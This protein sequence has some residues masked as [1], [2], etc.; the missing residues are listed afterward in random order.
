MFQ[1][2]VTKSDIIVSKGQEQLVS[3]A[4][5]IYDGFFTFDSEWDG[6]SKV[7]V[8]SNDKD[9]C[10]PI[11]L[12]ES[13]S[14]TIP[15]EVL[16]NAGDKVKVGV[17]GTNGDSENT[18]VLPSVWLPLGTLVQGTVLCEINPEPGPET[19]SL[20]QQLLN[21]ATEAVQTADSVVKRA[22]AGEFNGS[23][24]VIVQSDSQYPLTSQ[25]Y[26]AVKNGQPMTIQVE[27]VQDFLPQD[28][29]IVPIVIKDITRTESQESNA[30]LFFGV[31]KNI[32]DN[33][34]TFEYR[35]EILGG[36]KGEQGPQG[37]Q[38]DP[39]PRGEKGPEGPIGPEGPEGPQGLR[40]PEGPQGPKG[41]QGSKGDQGERGPQGLQGPK[42]DTGAPFQIVKVYNSVAAMESDFN[43]DD[44]LLGQFVTIDTGNVND[45]DNAKLFVKSESGWL[46]LTDLSGAQG[47]QGPIGPEGPQGVQGLRGL[48]GEQGPKGDP[49]KSAYEQAVE[50]GY[51]GTEAEFATLIK[52]AGEGKAETAEK[53]E[54]ARTI[55]GA[56]FDGTSNIDIKYAS[57]FYINYTGY[58]T[59]YKCNFVRLRTN[60]TLLFSIGVWP[61]KKNIY[62][63]QAS[64]NGTLSTRFKASV[65]QIVTG[66][67]TIAFG[68]YIEDGYFYVGINSKEYVDGT[69]TVLE[70][71][72]SSAEVGILNQSKTIPDGWTEIPI[73]S[74][75]SDGGTV[76][77]L[78]TTITEPS[79]DD[80][81]VSKGWVN[82]KSDTKVNKAGDTM[83]GDLIMGAYTGNTRSS[84][85][86]LQNGSD[87]KNAVQLYSQPFSSN[88]ILRVADRATQSD[89]IIRGV[90]TGTSTNDAVN[91]GQLNSAI[92]ALRT[93]LAAALSL[94][95]LIASDDVNIKENFKE[96]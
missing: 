60:A 44:V 53:L 20:I 37:P 59:F 74:V 86:R 40:G 65:T 69:I 68:Y 22:D 77:E 78:H 24:V 46:Y 26:E 88:N 67:S 43:N 83:T 90:K 9:I 92:S 32:E 11:Y 31:I 96:D 2:K 14:F 29:I 55:N 34:I 91:V 49:G 94:P 63:V 50:V 39:G 45:L 21:A 4:V 42:G 12:D 58:T 85:L 38:G 54:T 48:T 28:N 3:G 27:N 71:P 17:Y 84:L 82:S 23:S 61:D 73:L 87:Q 16:I 10:I 62:I 80:V 89:I 7:A 75:L 70:Y 5:N 25:E 93:E 79:A 76:G 8:F 1:I 52:K 33:S 56:E 41:D 47:I 57:S 30:G 81:L 19:P 35:Q 64:T 6:L 13:N 51:T 66:E 15:R 18:R 72:K 95:S 36:A